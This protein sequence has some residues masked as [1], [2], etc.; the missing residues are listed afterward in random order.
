MK[1]STTIN[2]NYSIPTA[3]ET[4]QGKGRV[5]ISVLILLITASFLGCISTDEEGWETEEFDG[6]YEADENTVLTVLN[7]NGHVEITSWDGDKIKFHA[8][9]KVKDDRKDELEEVEIIVNEGN[10]SISI[11]AEFKK[12]SLDV[13]VTMTI[14]VP[15]N[16]K[17]KSVTTSNGKLEISGVSS[18]LIL[19]SSNGEIIAEDIQGYVTAQ[20]SNGFL[21]IRNVEGIGDLLTSNGMITADVQ[22]F[23]DNITIQTSNGGIKVY[24]SPTLN[25][26]I[27][28]STINGEV[29]IHE[30]NL[31]LSKDEAKNKEGIL[32]SGGYNINIQTSNGHID[33]YELK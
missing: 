5:I 28:M 32:G 8:E 10:N 23:Q 33:V 6:E 11:E 3:G 18:N 20:T 16:V 24:I 13:S 25:A 19:A 15:K 31:D 14:K 26:N 4:M 17:V 2:R 12:P 27:T 21:T 9:K 7:V 29:T 30:L 1:A 22:S